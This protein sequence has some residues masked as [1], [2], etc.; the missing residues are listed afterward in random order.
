[1]ANEF[2]DQ[3]LSKA[4]ITVVQETF[5]KTLHAEMQGDPVVLERDIIEYESRMRVFPMEKFN[6]PVYVAC[7]NFYLSQKHLES[8]DTVGTFLFFVKEDMA[9]KLLKAFGL[10]SRD[11]ED[12]EVLMN[13][14][15]EFSSILAGNL[16]NEFMT[17]GYADLVIADPIK[18]K[19]SI[20]DGVPFDYS[21]Y[22]KQEVTF[23]FWNQRCI[24]IEACLGSVPRSGK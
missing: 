10:S 1:M 2:D 23:K 19:N 14:L 7:V 22:R 11:A 13:K 16:K 17:L 24:V 12:E 9:E 5:R 8:Q 3:V 21:L 18:A 6:G 4:I 20:P 15:G